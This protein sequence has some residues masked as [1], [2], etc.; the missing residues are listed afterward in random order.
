MREM[1]TRTS[2][3][4]TTTTAKN[5]TAAT[6]TITKQRMCNK[7]ILTTAPHAE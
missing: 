1:V 3:T 7:Q 6:W 4:T 5:I 2:T